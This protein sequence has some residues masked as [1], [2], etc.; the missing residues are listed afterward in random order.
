M[1]VISLRSEVKRSQG[2]R[3]QRGWLGTRKSLAFLSF[4]PFRYGC[5][6][7]SFVTTH[8][9]PCIGILPCPS[10]LTLHFHGTLPP[11]LQPE[12]LVW[13]ITT[14]V[15]CILYSQSSSFG[16]SF[17]IVFVRCQILKLCFPELP[18]APSVQFSGLGV[19]V[20]VSEPWAV[21]LTFLLCGF[22]ICGLNISEKTA[23]VLTAFRRFLLVSCPASTHGNYV[24]CACKSFA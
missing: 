15:Y 17:V 18:A 20:L 11:S 6:S 23:P 12:S 13:H 16:L 10:P 7:C 21:H 24:R 5:C 22:C 8:R 2:K 9:L 14:T 4:P 19:C 3:P 1:G